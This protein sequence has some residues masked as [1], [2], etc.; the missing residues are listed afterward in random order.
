[1]A[2]LVEGLDPSVHVVVCDFGYSIRSQKAR[3]VCGTRGY[4]APAIELGRGKVDY[5]KSVDLYSIRVTGLGLIGQ[6]LPHK[7]YGSMLDYEG[8]VGSIV[9]TAVAAIFHTRG[10]SKHPRTAS[11]SLGASLLT[12]P[13]S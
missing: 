4:W 5:N 8:N 3:E 13:R 2:N 7:A 6:S 12:K 1:M 9:R 11:M 10:T